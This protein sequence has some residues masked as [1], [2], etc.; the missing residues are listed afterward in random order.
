LRTRARAREITFV[1][2]MFLQSWKAKA[3][4]WEL[5]E[6]VTL[7]ETARRPGGGD[8]EGRG[9][10]VRGFGFCCRRREVG[11]FGLTQQEKIS[12]KS[13]CQRIRKTLPLNV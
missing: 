8:G 10:G 4:R 11:A 7:S 9:K 5:G 13:R 2:I 12:V 1:L 6:T 3:T